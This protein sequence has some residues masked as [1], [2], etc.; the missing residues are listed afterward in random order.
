MRC[1]RVIKREFYR[2]HANEARARHARGCHAAMP[3]RVVTARY[4]GNG[5]PYSVVAR[6]KSASGAS[7]GVVYETRGKGEFGHSE[8]TGYAAGE[9]VGVAA[10]ERRGR[11]N[12]SRTA[13]GY[14][15]QYAFV[16]VMVGRRRLRY[17]VS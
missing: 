9:R 2:C 15:A 8:R 3:L 6:W 4:A 16:G 17:K 11:S 10:G 13:S 14:Q 7:D 12:R 5:A 1:Q